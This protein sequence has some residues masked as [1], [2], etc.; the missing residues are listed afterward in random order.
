[1]FLRNQF[2]TLPKILIALLLTLTL[3]MTPARAITFGEPDGDRH[4]NVGVMVVTISDGRTILWCTGS[5]IAPTVFLTAAHCIEPLP[6]YG[7]AFDQ[8]WVTFDPVVN[9]SSTLIRGTAIPNPEFGKHQGDT[10]PHDIAV[11]ILNTPVTH[12]Q[13]VQLPSAGYFDQL[14][15]DGTLRDLSVTAVGYG[16]VRDDK[17]MGPQNNFRTRERHFVSQTFQALKPIF[18]QFSQNPSTGDGGTCYG[19][20]GGP[21]FV[22]DSNLVIAI[23]TTGDT[24]CRATDVDYRLDTEIA[25]TF[26]AQ[27]VEL[28]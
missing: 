28:P 19:D 2:L 20:S 16:R 18:V 1:M 3:T 13:P 14:K 17:T 10:Q 15:A 27:Y 12:I 21:H 22:G 26:L 4:P 9:E 8:V 11:V 24:I 5:L 7:V 23:T 25:Q 6:E